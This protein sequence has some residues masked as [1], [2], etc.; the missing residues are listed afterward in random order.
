MQGFDKEKCIKIMWLMK[1]DEDPLEYY[2]SIVL[3]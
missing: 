2:V 1:I 3:N